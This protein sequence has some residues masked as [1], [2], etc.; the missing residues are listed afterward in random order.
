L[1]PDGYHRSAVKLAGLRIGGP[2]SKM[3][4]ED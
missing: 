3:S 2:P 4:E 1:F